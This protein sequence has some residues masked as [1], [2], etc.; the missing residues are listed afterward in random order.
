M[1]R[2]AEKSDVKVEATKPSEGFVRVFGDLQRNAHS[3]ERAFPHY[4]SSLKSVAAAIEN[5]KTRS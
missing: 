5:L 1:V 2:K 3:Q 4:G